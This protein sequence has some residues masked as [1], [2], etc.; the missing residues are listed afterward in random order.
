MCTRLP[1]A[2]ALFALLALAGCGSAGKK[3]SA[4]S[5]PTTPPPT[6]AATTTQPKPTA[7]ECPN[8]LS[9]RDAAAV[10]RRQGG[11]RDVNGRSLGRSWEPD[12][13]ATSTS[14]LKRAYDPSLYLSAVAGGVPGGGTASSPVQVFLFHKGCYLGTTTK[15]PR[16]ALT[17]E[18]TQGDTVVVHYKHYMPRDANCC[19]SLPDYVVPYRW[20]GRKVVPLTPIPPP[21]QGM[22]EGSRTNAAVTTPST[23]D[24]GGKVAPSTAFNISARG[25]S[26]SDARS[27]AKAA[28]AAGIG[29]PNE[30]D[31]FACRPV[32]NARP[33][34]TRCTSGSRAV[35]FQS[36]QPE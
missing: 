15:E 25:I 27:V 7:S 32:G 26:C 10:V 22:K 20:N 11:P 24:C 16:F 5:A 1:A 19:P 21:D 29:G 4:T 3:H 2:P 30:V 13:S 35:R 9:A 8:P 23:L 34:T 33:V 6:A 18:Q 28:V 31:S 36:G 17:V 14:R 12:T